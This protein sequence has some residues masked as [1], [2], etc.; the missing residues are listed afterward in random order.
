[1]NNTLLRDIVKTTR[2]IP[3]QAA[4]KKILEAEEKIA[5]EINTIPSGVD[6]ILEF[7]KLKGEQRA[8]IIVDKTKSEANIYKNGEIID[9]FEVGV[10]T[11]IGDDLH[12]A[13]YD[14][15]SCG[16]SK[17]GRYTPS[18]QFRTGH[19]FNDANN[20][21]FGI[22]LNGV[23]HPVGFKQSSYIAIHKIFNK[24]LAERLPMFKTK[25]QRRGISAGC[26]N[27]IPDEFQRLAD[28]VT[29]KAD[30][31]ILP[32]EPNNKLEL[33]SL[34]NG[35]WFKT[36][37]ADQEKENIFLDAMRKFFKLDE[38]QTASL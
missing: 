20:H 12:T 15:N 19:I 27:I 23:Q 6:K 9:Q 2:R 13:I 11:N 5:Q 10:G 24:D 17:E 4:D 34:P 29:P 14:F 16:W 37:Y 28:R 38:T 36:K 25:G 32:E 31:F 1:M 3:L 18:G 22:Y 26:V 30:V 21:A 35:L 7:E 33:V 8:F